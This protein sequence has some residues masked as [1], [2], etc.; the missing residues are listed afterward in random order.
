MSDPKRPSTN[1]IP[2]VGCVVGMI[3]IILG[4]LGIIAVMMLSRL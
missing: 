1:G 3:M 4:A 2:T